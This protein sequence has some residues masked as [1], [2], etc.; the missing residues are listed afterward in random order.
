MEILRIIVCLQ[1][2]KNGY[3]T[4]YTNISMYINKQSGKDDY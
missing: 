1:I 2:M 3:Y 4:V